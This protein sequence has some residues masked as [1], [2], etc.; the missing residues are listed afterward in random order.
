MYKSQAQLDEELFQ[1]HIKK[2]QAERDL[3][4]KMQNEEAEKGYSFGREEYWPNRF[5]VY[6]KW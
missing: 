6:K 1:E 3:D 2:I 4:E 5:G